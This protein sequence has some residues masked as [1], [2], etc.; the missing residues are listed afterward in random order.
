MSCDAIKNKLQNF[1]CSPS[2]YTMQRNPEEK[3]HRGK[4]IKDEL[5]NN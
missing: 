3:L 2:R 1:Y 4:N 5:G